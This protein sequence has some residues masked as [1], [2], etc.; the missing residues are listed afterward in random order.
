MFALQGDHPCL[1]LCQARIRQLEQLRAKLL[2][3]PGVRGRIGR[4]VGEQF[5]RGRFLPQ[6]PDHAGIAVAGAG[7]EAAPYLSP[8]LL[9]P[10]EP[11]DRVLTRELARIEAEFTPGLGGKGFE[12][13]ALGGRVESAFDPVEHVRG[14]VRSQQ[15]VQGACIPM[16]SAQLGKRLGAQSGRGMGQGCAGSGIVGDVELEASAFGSEKAAQG[17]IL[18]VHMAEEGAGDGEP[19]EELQR[20]GAILCAAQG[21]PANAGQPEYEHCAVRPGSLRHRASNGRAQP[22]G[23]AGAGHRIIDAQSQKLRQPFAQGGD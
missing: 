14:Q 13:A 7:D 4:P 5:R 17:P 21:L 3:R 12:T 2:F 22:D 10:G 16:P 20:R 1:R 11:A 23:G 18:A 8:L 6:Q 15:D 19:D 9:P